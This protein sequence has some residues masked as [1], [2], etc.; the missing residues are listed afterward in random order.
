MFVFVEDDS[1]YD[2]TLLLVVSFAMKLIDV[3]DLNPF[4]ALLQVSETV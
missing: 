1:L 4:A 3:R 2:T